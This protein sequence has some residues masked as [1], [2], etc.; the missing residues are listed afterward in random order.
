MSQIFKT[1]FPKHLFVEFLNKTMLVEQGMYYQITYEMY[2]KLCYN[3][4]L[5]E[6][7]A[8]CKPYYHL[9]KQFYLV[10]EMTYP[11]FLTVLRQL[12]C[13]TEMQ[14]VSSIKYDK[15][16]YQIV[17]TIYANLAFSTI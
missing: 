5:Q 11:H 3:H 9:S 13:S 4:S 16:K 7:I 6:F 10:R 2:K 1:P 17:L 8:I 12:C 15:S 14:Y